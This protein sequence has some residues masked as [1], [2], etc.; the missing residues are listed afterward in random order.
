MDL[1]FG[2]VHIY[3]LQKIFYQNTAKNKQPLG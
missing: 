1:K 3:H 2:N